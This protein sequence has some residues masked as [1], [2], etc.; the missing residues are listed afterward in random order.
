MSTSTLTPEKKLLAKV[1]A[2]E[3]TFEQGWWKRAKAATLMYEKP[4]GEDEA[5]AYPFNILYANTEILL[6]ALYSATPRPD[7][8]QRWDKPSVPAQAVERLL[9]LLVDDNTPGTESFDCALGGSV[10]SAL[11]PGAGGVRIRHF[12]GDHLPV[13]WEEYKY[14]QLIWAD[15]KKWSK[16]PWICFRHHMSVEEIKQQ[17]PDVKDEDLRI[18]KEDAADP[19]AK[20]ERVWVYEVWTKKDRKTQWLCEEHADCKLG[21]VDD[22]PLKLAGFYPTPGIL[23]L[24]RKPN[25]MEPVPL[26]DYYRNQAEELNRVTVR[27]NAI[28]SA[29]RVRGA[30]NS[31][32]AETFRTIFSAEAQDNELVG[33]SIPMDPSGASGLDK[34]IWLAPIEK[35]IQVARE[36]YSA[37]QQILQVVYQLTGLADIVRG[38]SV[39][40]ETATAQELKSKWGTVRLRRMQRTVQ[41]YIRDLLRLATDAST[42]VLQPPQWQQLTQLDLPFAA[43]KQQAMMQYQQAAMEAEATQQQPPPPP[44][45]LM[46]PTWEEVAAALASDELRTLIIDIETDSSLEEDATAD[47]QDVTEFMA[48]LQGLGQGLSPLAAMG[49]EGLRAIK[50]ITLAVMRKFKLGREVESALKALPE[51]MP[52]KGDDESEKVKLEVEKLKL[53]GEQARSQAEQ[54]SMQLAGKL[55]QEKHA[56][57]MQALQRKQAMDVAKHQLEMQKMA[58]QQR[59]LAMQAALP[60]PTAAKPATKRP[61]PA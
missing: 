23:T 51:S 18:E 10:L 56:M 28:L 29:I 25:D 57:D 5:K 24:V 54:A 12:P 17:F 26:Y 41:T 21:S 36:L 16:L 61:A 11:V 19:P 14:D 27:L 31:I 6:P 34:H 4:S 39:A 22:D 58:M 13:R 55:A 53:Q 9:T 40:S 20:L 52:D 30:Y 50:T 1:Q 33:T 45:V 42:A 32:M 7:V 48:A 44:P 37:R 8:V 3:K 38:A 46:Q 2:R 60:Q 43:Q 47:R 35:L 59:Q 49:P 15:G